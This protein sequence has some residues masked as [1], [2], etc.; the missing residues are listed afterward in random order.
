[1][2][3][4]ETD[5]RDPTDMGLPAP[6]V[7]RETPRPALPIVSSPRRAHEELPASALVE[8]LG[9]FGISLTEEDIDRMDASARAAQAEQLD[10]TAAARSQARI[11]QLASFGVPTKDL[12]AL[13][14]DQLDP[15]DA[16]AAIE[17]FVAR[18]E[19][20]R[21]SCV[22]ILIGETGSGKTC[23][24]AWWLTLPAAKH[25]HVATLDPYFIT[26]GR[27]ARTSSFSDAKMERIEL[28]EK[29]VIDDLGMEYLDAKG[30]FA[31]K[32]DA[33]MDARYEHLLPT[34]ITCNMQPDEL[35]RDLGP[36][37]ASRLEETAVMTIVHGSFRK[38]P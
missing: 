28:A 18:H 9:Q 1:M 4:D 5:D 17:R 7:A 26:G 27:I 31:A 29:L 16:K 2:S 11:A 20:E 8:R 10:R 15:S 33:I 19:R 25:P 24:A 30:A 13:A 36:R 23:A 32:L 21:R 12:E 34:V 38:R 14:A 22:Q 3:D 6:I 37:I 35:R